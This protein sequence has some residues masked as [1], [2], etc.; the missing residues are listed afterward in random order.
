MVHNES[1][2]CTTRWL[3][4]LSTEITLWLDAERP[5]TWSVLTHYG[6]NANVRTDH[7]IFDFEGGGEGGGVEEGGG[8]SVNSGRADAGGHSLDSGQSDVQRK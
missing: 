3:P 5:P 1:F 2:L 7:V 8:E 4:T 6:T